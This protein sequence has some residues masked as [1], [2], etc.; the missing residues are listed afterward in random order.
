MSNQSDQHLLELSAFVAVANAGG[1]TAATRESGKRKA[2]LSKRV[3]DLETRLG[4]SL[5][6]RTTRKVSLT[7]AGLAYLEHA[8]NVFRELRLAEDFA[9]EFV[10]TPSGHLSVTVGPAFAE[11]VFDKAVAPFLRDWPDT[12]VDLDVS[13]RHADLTGGDVDL[14]IRPGPLDDS[15]LIHRKI[16]SFAG[17]Y[18]ASAGYL[19]RY[20]A[21]GSPSE[22]E[23][24]KLINVKRGEGGERWPF[25][26]Q[27][28]IRWVKIE[29]KLDTNSFSIALSAARRGLGIARSPL[30]GI[31]SQGGLIP[32]LQPYWPGAGHLH[33]VYSERKAN[34][35]ILRAF[36]DVLMLISE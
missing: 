26:I 5:F 20:G 6:E 34:L 15:S 21:P 19:Q 1:F 27:G 4:F 30:V 2:T 33:A 25:T 13:G 14:A 23:A 36:L 10:A 3:A 16:A 22:L 11:L 17:G 7:R 32:V 12:T 28:E 8:T 9:R 18:F 29:P 35:P 31:T 24:H